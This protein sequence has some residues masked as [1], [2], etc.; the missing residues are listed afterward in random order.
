MVT[1]EPDTVHTPVVAEENDTVKPVLAVADRE[2]LA[3]P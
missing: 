2:K 1:V 3:S